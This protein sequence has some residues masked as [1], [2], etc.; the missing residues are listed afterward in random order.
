ML[1]LHNAAKLFF[2]QHI[3][4]QFLLHASKEMIFT[5]QELQAWPVNDLTSMLQYIRHDVNMHDE[6]IFVLQ[7]L[8]GVH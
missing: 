5:V 6:C 2:D 4:R 7:G 8:V 1:T 3:L